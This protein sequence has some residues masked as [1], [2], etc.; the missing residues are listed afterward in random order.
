MNST[1]FSVWDP[2]YTR[3]IM[4]TRLTNDPLNMITNIIPLGNET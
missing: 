4:S 1:E 3:M 2:L